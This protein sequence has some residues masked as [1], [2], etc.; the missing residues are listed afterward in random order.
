MEI[1]GI[2]SQSV[3]VLKQ[4]KANGGYPK[5]PDTNNKPVQFEKNNGKAGFK[6]DIQQSK[7]DDRLPNQA[8]LNKNGF[9]VPFKSGGFGGLKI[10]DQP[11]L[12]DMNGGR[13]YQNDKGDTIRISNF[14]AEIATG[15]NGSTQVEY[16]SHDGKI[17]DT[18]LYDPDGNPLKGYLTVKNDD[19][20]IVKYEYEYDINGNKQ[21]KRLSTE[22]AN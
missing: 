16:N 6:H 21:V 22:Y 18:V 20:S 1:N 11:Y 3:E 14:E 13:T 19:G 2:H 12:Q 17:S 15:M 5:T 7:L 8:W 9:N 4:L 10:G